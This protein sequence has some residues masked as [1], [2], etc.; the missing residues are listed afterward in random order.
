MIDAPLDAF[1]PTLSHTA[2]RS[3]R[4]SSSRP[5]ATTGRDGAAPA[6][7]R[8]SS[9]WSWNSSSRTSRLLPSSCWVRRHLGAQLLRVDDGAVRDREDRRD[10]RQHQPRH[11]S[12]ELQYVLASGHLALTRRQSFRTSDYAEDDARWARRGERLADGRLHRLTGTEDAPRRRRAGPAGASERRA[13]QFDDPINIQYTSGTTG[14]PKG[15]TLATTTSSTTAT[16]SASCCDYTEPDRVCIPRALLPLLRHGL[17]NLACTTHGACMVVPAEASTGHAARA[18]Q[19]E[20]SPRSTACRR[21]SSPSS[22]PRFA[23]Y[24][25]STC[26]PGS[27]PALLVRSR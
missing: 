20:R 15:A 22:T 24:D 27:W 17:G 2:V 10:P 23:D 7:A 11:R 5:S 26:A 18:T 14:F 1:G 12:H 25:L 13:G 4:P 9:T 3:S 21:C 19:E 8:P 16:S 6:T